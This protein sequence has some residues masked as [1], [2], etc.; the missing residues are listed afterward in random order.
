MIKFAFISCLRAAAFLA[1]FSLCSAQPTTNPVAGSIFGRVTSSSSDSYL[2]RVRVSIEGTS[3]ETFTDAGGAYRLESV[4]VGTVKLKLF[5]TGMVPYTAA[6]TVVAAQAVQHNASLSAFGA[7]EVRSDIVKLDQFVVSSSKEMAASAIAINEQRFAPNLKSVVATDEFGYVA[8]GHV[9]E[10]MKFLPGVSINYAGG[11]A[12]EI[13]LN[14]VPGA[15]VPVTIGGFSLATAV[16][17]GTSRSSAVE[18]VSINGISRID[19]SFSPTPDSQGMALAGSVNMVPRSAFERTHPIL[20][21]STFVLMRK[22]RFLDTNPTPGPRENRDRKVYP[23]FDASWVVPINN[24]LGFTLSAGRS[25]AFA[26]QDQLTNTWRGVSAATNGTTF[27]STTADQPYLSTFV[28]RGGGKETTRNSLGGTLDYK[29][30]ANDVLSL[31]LQVATFEENFLSQILTFNVGAVPPGNF[32]LSMTHGTVGA[33]NMTLQ[34]TG[35]Y[36]KNRTYMPT[37]AWRH[38]GRVWKAEAGIGLSRATYTGDDLARGYFSSATAQRS[39]VTV[40]FDD[41]YYL[42]PNRITVTDGATGAPIDPYKIDTYAVTGATSGQPIS[43]DT[44]RNLFANLRRDFTWTV[45]VTLKAGVDLRQSE[46]DLRNAD[47]IAYSFV[48][49]DGRASTTPIGSDDGAAPFWSP[50]LS[51]HTSAYGFPALQVVGVNRLASYYKD[52][53]T[54]LTYDA[55][56]RYRAIVS[57]SKAATELVSAAF[58]RGDVAL[59]EQRLKLVGGLRVEQTNDDAR[60]PL[61]DATRNYQRDA[62]GRV[63]LDA[64]GKPL[65]ILPTTDTLGV[66]KLTFLDRGAHTTKEYLRLFPSLNASYNLRENLIARGAYYWS[67][68]RPDFNQYSGGI[69]LPDTESLPSATNR[70]TVN[71]AGVKAWS[72]R[73][74]MV[75]FEYY[76]AGVGELSVG[77]FVRDFKNFF[78]STVT[79]PTNAFLGFYGLDPATYGAYDV[80]TQQNIAGGVRMTGMT[81]S[82][83]QALTGLPSWARGV[84][85]FA[86][87]TLNRVV[88]GDNTATG[89][90]A[91]YI[92]STYNWGV[93]LNRPKFNVRANWNYRGRQRLAA[94]TGI[95]IEPGTYNW[96][97]RRLYVDLSGEYTLTRNFGLFAQVRN[98]GDATEDQKMIGPHTPKEAQFSGRLEFYP[99]WTVGLKGTF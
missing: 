64:N 6:V 62:S 89:N 41:I 67:V 70:I 44:Q 83:K 37:L 69:T 36:R 87:S 11:N 91:G 56:T 65:N 38:E 55:N 61:T 18:M 33:G 95:G 74:T 16:T 92:P 22:N 24:R 94:V 54:A 31:S 28:L 42:H 85:V 99:L 66:S 10:F 7:K 35:G 68:G 48:G 57:A 72:A 71:N 20:N 43:N 30:T 88:P 53:P 73:T 58:L 75:R 96:Y 59:F 60:G 98:V 63:V 78:G 17:S 79:R 34:N 39:G 82:Y 12:R 47:S 8:E 13:S 29:L 97:T 19:V 9:G 90:F 27:P 81:F 80:A 1:A 40:S 26:G 49:K 4:P 46:R 51:E 50:E 5:Y 23:G 15:Y 14:G 86:N 2:G 93:S 25:E 77:G 52:N 76:F 32:N 84:Q 45:P 21:V 3:L